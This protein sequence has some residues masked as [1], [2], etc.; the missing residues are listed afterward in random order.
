MRFASV[1]V[2]GFEPFGQWAVNPSAE[3]A[4]A[5]ASALGDIG[6]S[7]V[8]PVT[9]AVARS[10]RYEHARTPAL[11]L[12]IG[13]A[14]QSKVPRVEWIARNRAGATPDN[15]GVVIAGPMAPDGP[16]VL[17]PR[18]DLEVLRS[19][20]A[21]AWDEPVESSLDCGGYVCNALLYWGLRERTDAESVFVHVPEWQPARARRF[22][23]VLAAC[24]QAW[25]IA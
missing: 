4:H 12:H 10:F 23:E 11:N 7:R 13:L 20:L 1:L 24:V 3:V 19:A 8:L 22:G 18:I 2:T 21:Q 15:D 16:E 6:Q 5:C 17:S 9:Y 14:G 25:P